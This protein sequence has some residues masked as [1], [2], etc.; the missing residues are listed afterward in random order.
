MSVNLFLFFSFIFACL[1]LFFSFKD[2]FFAA[3]KSRRELIISSTV[4]L[5]KDLKF[6]E[7][8][9]EKSYKEYLVDKHKTE[10]WQEEA[11]YAYL[12][13]YTQK[14]LAY[15]AF[16]NDEK[17]KIMLMK[18]NKEKDSEIIALEFLIES[19]SKKA[20]SENFQLNI[21]FAQLIKNF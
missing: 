12:S 16:I 9:R 1:I 19:L 8:D 3:L 6:V 11:E 5:K 14:H 10:D 7:L 21:D 20:A 13:C 4:S 2:L 17:N 15:K 18:K